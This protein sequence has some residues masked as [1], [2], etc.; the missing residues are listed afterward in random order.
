MFEGTIYCDT[1]CIII[2][3]LKK[4]IAFTV[5]ELKGENARTNEKNEITFLHWTC[6]KPLLHNM[7]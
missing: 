5:I 1:K 2:F 3:L 4:G 6:R 7:C